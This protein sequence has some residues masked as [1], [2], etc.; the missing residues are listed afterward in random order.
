MNDSDQ[1]YTHVLQ[2]TGILRSFSVAKVVNS[3]DVT[4]L[5]RTLKAVAKNDEEFSSMLAEE[6]KKLGDLHDINSPVPGIIYGIKDTSRVGML[7][8]ISKEITKKLK[9]TKALTNKELAFIIKMM[10]KELGLSQDDFDNSD[11]VD[12]NS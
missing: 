6:I 2:K 11:D 12:V 5:K 1:A 3:V 4:E 10:V 9:P 7:A 8:S